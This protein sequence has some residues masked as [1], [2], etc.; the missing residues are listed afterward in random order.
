MCVLVAAEVPAVTLLH[1]TATHSELSAVHLNLYIPFSWEKLKEKSKPFHFLHVGFTGLLGL[2][3]S[4]Y[5][6][7]KGNSQQTCASS[8]AWGQTITTAVLWDQTPAAP[9]SGI[10]RS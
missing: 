3:G 2:L 5:L 10:L 8:V 9:F 1:H 6:Q 7:N 4:F